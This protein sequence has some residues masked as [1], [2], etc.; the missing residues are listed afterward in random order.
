[1][2]LFQI[3]TLVILSAI[4]VV[5]SCKPDT[6]VQVI[7]INAAS[8]EEVTENVKKEAV[9]TVE[10][11][12]TQAIQTTKTS[13]NSNTNAP[14]FLQ[15]NSQLRG[16][17]YDERPLKLWVEFLGEKRVRKKNL[18]DGKMPLEGATAFIAGQVCDTY[19]LKSPD[20]VFL[21]INGGLI[22]LKAGIETKQKVK[23]LGSEN[24]SHCGFLGQIPIG[25]VAKKDHNLGF[26]VVS[27][28]SYFY[29]DKIDDPYNH[30][31]NRQLAISL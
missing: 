27:G 15:D 28:N 1:M 4:L 24:Y 10:S 8:T 18:T 6:T 3:S 25:G 22:E 16:L 11:A 21:S 5:S 13:N 14:S 17:K 23:N 9:E 7:D 19:N 2:K 30:L 31:N 29:V 20:K 26:V 12:K